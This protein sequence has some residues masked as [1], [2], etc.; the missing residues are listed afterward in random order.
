ML[1][2]NGGP[3]VVWNRSDPNFG[4]TGFEA[5][6]DG[7]NG[8]PNGY[9]MG[10]HGTSVGSGGISSIFEMPP[11]QVGFD[12]SGFSSAIPCGAPPGTACREEP[13]V[14]AFAWSLPEYLGAFGGWFISGGTSAA[15]P[16]W[17]GFLALVD[18]SIPQGRLGLVSPALYQIEASDPSAFFDVTQ[19]NND[20]LAQGGNPNN[21]ICTYNGVAD[22]PCYE[23]TPGYDMASGLG[24]P[25]AAHLAADLEG[26]Q[27]GYTL[28]ASDGGVFSF[29]AARFYGSMGG[30]PLSKPVVGLATT[31]GGLGYD[32]VAS[33]GGVFAFGDAPFYG[34]MG[35]RPLNQPVVGMA[36]TP[37]GKG[38]WEVA[39]DGGLFAFGD[40]AY[41]GSMGG[42]PLN[43][44]VVGM[45][46]TADGKGYWE[47]ASDGGLFAFGGV[48]FYGSTGGQVLNQPVV[49][50]GATSGG[51]R[52]AAR[53][54]GVFAFGAAP[55]LGSLAGLVLNAPVVGM[56]SGG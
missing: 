17:A 41:Y 10:F 9:P 50:I 33:D 37:D 1:L 23:A 21:Y 47:V 40:A 14:S 44:P 43:Q 52:E 7:Q 2:T 6:F 24:T 30:K 15:G 20:Y 53:D 19:G 55:F 27:F 25:Q 16:L 38:Y 54:G 46:A 8:R 26:L 28:V 22:Q 29:G 42:K 11:W 45:A 49:G 31:P 48:P 34:S 13:D 3:E 35:G 4:G 5:P 56:A 39:S 32:E 12:H 36:A 51:Y 18:G